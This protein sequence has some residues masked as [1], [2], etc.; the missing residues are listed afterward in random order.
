MK[1]SIFQLHNIF[2]KLNKNDLS[3]NEQNF[4]IKKSYQISISFLK[5]KFS[6]KLNFLSLDESG[7]EDLAM[8][9]IVPLF[10]KNRYNTLGILRALQKWNDPIEN[11]ADADYFL[12]RIIW[13]RVDQSVTKILK[14]RDPIFAKILKTLKVCIANNNYRQVRHF[15]TVFILKYSSQN[16]IID[17]PVINEENFDLLPMEYFTYKQ[18]KLFDII[19]NYLENETDYFPAIPLNILVKRIRNYHY[20]IINDS[21]ENEVSFDEKFSFDLIVE[22]ALSSIKEKLDIYY[23]AKNKM[24]ED[25][26]EMIYASF[27]N[28]SEDLV[29][30]G[31]QDSLFAYLKHHNPSL[32]K[33][34]FYSKYNNRMSY[35]LSL[36]KSD[37]IEK[38]SY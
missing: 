35:L 15:G 3:R 12:S 28:I 18:K 20:S 26:A 25:E 31:I 23:V 13:R 24:T 5:A 37:L 29:H 32:T 9:A 16:K 11:D 14:E 22:D 21:D 6:T 36:F 30:G 8:D 2:T 38:V 33:E 10:V 4:L 7:L 1:E 27:S 17:G 34:V 19:F